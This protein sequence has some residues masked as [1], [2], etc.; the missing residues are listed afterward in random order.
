MLYVVL[1]MSLF[2]QPLS[3]TSRS[4]ESPL[5]PNTGLHH[6]EA[7]HT[8]KQIRTSP[9]QTHSPRR[10]HTHAIR[11]RIPMR[12]A[13]TIVSWCTVD[14]LAWSG[15]G[16]SAHNTHIFYVVYQSVRFLTVLGLQAQLVRY[17]SECRRA[18]A[19]H[20]LKLARDQLH[21]C[22]FS[23]EAS[24]W[25]SGRGEGVVLRTAR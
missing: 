16:T 11:M 22:G 14:W 1:W 24:N 13:R 9:T 4:C 20:T 15:D 17:A 3:C 7:I 23:C 25:M 12:I 18:H 8:H 5:C 10:V 19:A 2:W 6:N 21:A